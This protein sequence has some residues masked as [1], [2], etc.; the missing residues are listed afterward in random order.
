MLNEIVS[1]IGSG[2]PDYRARAIGSG[3]PGALATYIV[4][5]EDMGG[6]G[7]WSSGF[8]V[9]SGSVTRLPP[10][11]PLS[12]NLPGRRELW[13]FNNDNTN[14]LFIGQSGITVTNG[15]PIPTGTMI[16]LKLSG[17]TNVF[18]IAHASINVLTLEIA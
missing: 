12:G 15:W 5:F 13:I 2:L 11:P 16:K 6:I 3:W 9:S 18:G 7:I 14:A 10:R 8:T 1:I 4:N 17:N